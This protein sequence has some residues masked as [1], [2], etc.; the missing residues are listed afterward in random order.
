MKTYGTY[1]VN[2]EKEKQ[3]LLGK[4]AVGFYCFPDLPVPEKIKNMVE[5]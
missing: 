1:F 5:D 2:D 4:N 3:L